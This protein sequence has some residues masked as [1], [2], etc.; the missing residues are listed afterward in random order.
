M[1]MAKPKATGLGPFFDFKSPAA[2]PR[3]TPGDFRCRPFEFLL[4]HHEHTPLDYAIIEPVAI[5]PTNPI[6]RGR[7]PTSPQDLVTGSEP[8]SLINGEFA[9][10]VAN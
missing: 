6:F 3:R 2:K 1:N 10:A 7:K 5:I 9:V 4:A 8:K